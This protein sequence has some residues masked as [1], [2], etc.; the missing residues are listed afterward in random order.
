MAN[1]AE[2]PKLRPYS[3]GIFQSAGLSPPKNVTGGEFLSNLPEPITWT[4]LDNFL[5]KE[6]T[7]NVTKHKSRKDL[8]FAVVDSLLAFTLL[9]SKNYWWTQLF[10]PLEDAVP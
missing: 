3:Q 7:Y 9:T 6:H 1:P 5:L 8:R 4:S 10:V 2:E